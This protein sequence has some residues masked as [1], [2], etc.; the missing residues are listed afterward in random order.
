MQNLHQERNIP[1]LVDSGSCVWF[2]T[3]L[4]IEQSVARSCFKSL[5]TLKTLKSSPDTKNL[6][7]PDL[8]WRYH[9]LKNLKPDNKWGNKSWRILTWKGRAR[10][11]IDQAQEF[12]I[13]VVNFRWKYCQMHRLWTLS[14][15]IIKLQFKQVIIK[16]DIC[17]GYK[18]FISEKQFEM[19]SSKLHINWLNWIK[20]GYHWQNLDKSWEMW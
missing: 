16:L 6:P 15:V 17:I 19:Y 4:T 18:P 8:G 20:K 3:S 14:K 2:P 5:L 11:A 10:I 1:S 9:H 12:Y 13:T 7:F